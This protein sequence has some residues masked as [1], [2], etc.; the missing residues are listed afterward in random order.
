VL[1]DSLHLWVENG[2]MAVLVALWIR[3]LAH[4]LPPGH[5][6]RAL[7]GSAPLY[8]RPEPQGNPA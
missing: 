6:V 1:M 2:I 7:W 8:P 4:A 3:G 5:P